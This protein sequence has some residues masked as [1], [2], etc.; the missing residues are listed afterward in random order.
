MHRICGIL[1][2]LASLQENSQNYRIVGVGRGGINPLPAK[3]D[4]LEF[5]AILKEKF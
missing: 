2:I 5:F 1:Q 3:A 4:S